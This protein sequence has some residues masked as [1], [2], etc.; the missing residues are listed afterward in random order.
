[1]ALTLDLS[2]DY[3]VWDNLEAITYLVAWASAN[4]A[5]EARAVTQAMR[6]APTWKEL[7]AANGAYTGQDLVWEIPAALLNLP[8]TPQNKRPGPKPGD[9]VKDANGDTWTVLEAALEAVGSV[10][11]LITRNMVIAWQLRDVVDIEQ[12]AITYDQDGAAVRIWPPTGGSIL[13]QNL[14][15]RV[16]PIEAVIAEARG[17]RGQ[18][19]N[20]QIFV[21]QQLTGLDV[22]ECR[23]KWVSGAQTHY[24]DLVRYH[25]A[26]RIDQLPVLDAVK[27]V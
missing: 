8:Q 3:L 25:E 18:E 4:G 1:M 9:Q 2:Q 14:A 26:E 24:L 7:A 10:W 22:R 17:M 6:R 19:A 15:A 16:Q 27:R 20:Y 13:F 12:S 5:E 23:L 11:R 21:S